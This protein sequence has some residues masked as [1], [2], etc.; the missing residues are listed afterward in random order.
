MVF[1][2]G[3]GNC[4]PQPEGEVVQTCIFRPLPPVQELLHDVFVIN[5]SLTAYDR[6]HGG[7]CHGCVVAPGSGRNQ[8]IPAGLERKP[9]VTADHV[10]EVDLSHFSS[11][12]KLNRDSES[13][14][15]RL[16]Q[17]SVHYRIAF[18][19]LRIQ[20]FKGTVNLLQ[21]GNDIGVMCKYGSHEQSFHRDPS[22]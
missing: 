17:Q 14:T 8:A 7:D 13:I 22:V 12:Q 1:F 4:A 20:L 5:L 6:R 3:P 9:A 21:L 15:D 11:A 2:K 18:K 10:P 19:K 16:S